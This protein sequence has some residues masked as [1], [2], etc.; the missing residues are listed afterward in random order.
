MGMGEF[1][2]LLAALFWSVTVILIRLSGLQIPPL[3]LTFFKSVMA[4]LFFALTIGC[5]NLTWMPALSNQDWLR[6]VASAV[7]GI[8]I[9][10]TMVVAA[11]KKLGASLNA[12]ADCI[13]APAMALVGFLMFDEGLNRWET[14][15]GLLVVAGV[16]IGLRV[17]KEVKDT[18]SLLMGAALAG[19]AHVVMAVGILM[20]RDIYREISVVWV[21]GF[22]FLIA[23]LVLLVVG[24]ISP[25]K[26]EL[27]QG[28]KRR[29][30][31]KWTIPM[32]LLGPYIATIFWTG[33][34]KH[35]TA[36]RAAIYNQLSTI[37]IVLLA[38]IFLKEKLTERRA[39]GI[40]LAAAGSILVGAN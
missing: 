33:G 25:S 13:Y 38:W 9:A 6:L 17:S 22:R 39:V 14:L 11:V 16:A 32:S 29:D 27:F 3:P 19:G 2:A 4:T 30:L 35:T 10:D 26:E 28:F 1:Q 12:L 20:A 36:A 5:L 34:F 21:S 7:L 24:L 37:F 15:G 31:W 18:K 23:S 8:S 40:A